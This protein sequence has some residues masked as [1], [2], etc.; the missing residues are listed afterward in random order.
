MARV[1]RGTIHTKRRANILRQARGF[2]GRRK[3]HL[4]E[5]RQA[6]IKAGQYAFRDRRK[7][8]AEFRAFWHVQLSAAAKQHGLSYSRFMYLLKQHDILLNR[9][10]LSLLAN[11]HPDIFRVIVDRVRKNE[12]PK[13]A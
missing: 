1:K 9:K 8:K 6:L 12:Q 2:R 4:R 10:M 3:S 13:S 5:A 11:E 7:K